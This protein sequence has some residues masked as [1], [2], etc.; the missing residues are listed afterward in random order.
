MVQQI[1]TFRSL[2]AGECLH[3]V[4]LDDKLHTQYTIGCTVRHGRALLVKNDGELN[5]W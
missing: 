4:E 2:K 1:S 5:L 3:C